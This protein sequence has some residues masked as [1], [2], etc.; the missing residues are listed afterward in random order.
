MSD[1]LDIEEYDDQAY[2]DYLDELY[3]EF[4]QSKEDSFNIGLDLIVC[5]WE[6]D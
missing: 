5:C 4:F 3:Y 1:Y 6:V 2:K